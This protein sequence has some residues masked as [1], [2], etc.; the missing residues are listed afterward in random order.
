MTDASN[1]GPLTFLMVGCQRCG[2]TWLDAALRDHPEVYLPRQK[3]TYFF[4]RFYDRGIEWYLQQFDGVEP[5]H[6]AVGEV[7]TGYCL[8]DVVPN[9]ARH[10]PDISIL[11]AVRHPL[12][13]LWSNYQV[14]KQEQGW[15]GLEQAIEEDPELLARSRYSEQLQAVLDHWD[16]SRVKVLFQEDL[17]QDDRA[18]FQ[19][20]CRFLGVDPTVDSNQFGQVKNSAM[21]PRIRRVAQAV[22]LRP[23]LNRLSL[24]PVG[25]TVR[26]MKKRSGKQGYE[27]MDPPVRQ[28]LLEYFRPYNDK[29]SELTGRDLSHWNQ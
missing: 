23:V 18:Y 14:R 27:S 24:S 26:R 8:L 20:T 17:D 15:S 28:R 10:F 16:A 2:T 4:D 21:F 9:V 19:D 13:R 5:R 1:D 12:D 6:R 11:M 25:N 3:Q 22:G 7:A 29:L